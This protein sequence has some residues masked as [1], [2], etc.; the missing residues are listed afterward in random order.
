MAVEV[1]VWDSFAALSRREWK[2][3]AGSRS[4]FQDA[5]WYQTMPPL[6]RLRLLVAYC[7][8]RPTAALPLFIVDSPA[9]YYHN[10][11]QLFCGFR[12]VTLLRRMGHSAAPL[13]Q[14]A[15]APW[16]PA[17]VSVSPYGYRGG[18]IIPEEDSQRGELASAVALAADRLCRKEAVRAAVYFYLNEADDREWIEALAELGARITV[19][20]AD[21]N[22]DLEWRSLEHYFRA[23]G[24]RGRR[25]RAEYRHALHAPDVQW[26][27]IRL[28]PQGLN[29][30]LSHKVA[31]LF[32]RT[33]AKYGDQAHFPSPGLVLGSWAGRRLLLFGEGKDGSPRSALLVYAKGRKLYPKFFGSTTTAGDYFFLTFS[34]L[35]QLAIAQGVRRIEYGGGS[36][37]AKLLRGAR[38]RWLLAAV[39]VY[40]KRLAI[41]LELFLPHYQAVK[42]AH[43]SQLA[44]RY[45]T[46]HMPPAAPAIVDG[47]SWASSLHKEV[48]P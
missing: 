22:L 8:G 10:P 31:A 42:I 30:E 16:F 44:A 23:L 27:A 24:N 37:E 35:I 18:V 25:Q 32:S 38:L 48:K 41:C 20:G 40:D 34:W 2:H 21:C 14:A 19:V 1:K 6:G 46:D 15:A 5:L 33:A 4:V 3:L 36:H 9:H 29:H 12:E 39:Q 13:E 7:S 17:M 11:S 45:Q 47:P 28:D 26:R 43:F